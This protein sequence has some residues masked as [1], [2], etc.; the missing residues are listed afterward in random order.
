MKLD[1]KSR[2]EVAF[3]DQRHLRVQYSASCQSTSDCFEN[4][5]RVNA[6]L[7][8]QYHRLGHAGDIQRYD[9][10]VGQ[11]GGIAAADFSDPRDRSPHDTKDVPDLFECLG[12]TAYH[13]G[14]CPLNGLGL[15][16]AYR[17]I[18]NNNFL[19]LCSFLKL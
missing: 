13:D 6:R 8:S 11:L 18:E 2:L 5:F 7:C 17:G 3:Q 1:A 12:R 9:D 10:L 14:Q 4:I 15:A 16:T 19:F